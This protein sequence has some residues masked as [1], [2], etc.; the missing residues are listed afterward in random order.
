MTGYTANIGELTHNNTNF[1]TVLYTSAHMQLVAMTLLPG[2]EIGSEV[3]ESVDQFF[4]IEE[5]TVK[6]VMNGEETVLQPEMV[7][8]IPAGTTH[9]VINIGQSSAKLYTIYAPPNHP[10]GTIHKTKAEAEA[11]EKAEHHL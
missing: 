1:R 2:E 7:A 4:R 3:H 10:A 5:G 6:I 11:A 9:N 8:I